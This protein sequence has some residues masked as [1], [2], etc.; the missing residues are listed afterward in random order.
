MGEMAGEDTVSTRKS[1]G[2]E[3][4]PVSVRSSVGLGEGAVR[5]RESLR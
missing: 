2:F 5:R 1:V 3:A 4:A